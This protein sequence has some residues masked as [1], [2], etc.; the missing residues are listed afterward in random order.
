[1]PFTNTIN[2]TQEQIAGATPEEL[3]LLYASKESTNPSLP[4]PSN[5]STIG[6]VYDSTLSKFGKDMAFMSITSYQGMLHGFFVGLTKAKRILEI[7]TFTGS[8]AIYFAT[9]LKRNGVPG[10]PGVD[11]HKPITSLEINDEYAQ[12]ARNNF[13]AAKVDEYIDVVVGD[14]LGSLAQLDGQVFDL[15]FIDADKPAYKLYYDTII[16]LNLLAKDGLF[17]I[18]NTAFN[19]VLSYMNAPAP[20]TED[21]ELL[22]VPYAGFP[23][24]PELGKVL[25]E[26]NEHIRA[27]PRT[28]V[29]MLPFLTGITLARFV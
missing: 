10:G 29:V 2:P 12:I 8:S 24:A 7:G 22:D 20:V 5:P 15:V 17:I 25:H 26:F 23:D 27:D 1:M 16:D 11:G 28:E 19:C 13:V 3:R 9:A 6:K 21:A 14:A 4:V 18:D